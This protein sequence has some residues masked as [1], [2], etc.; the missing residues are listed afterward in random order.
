MKIKTVLPGAV[1]CLLAASCYTPRYMYSPSAQNVPVLVKK[2]DS[3]LSANYSTDL[4][5]SPFPGFSS[6]SNS[7]KNN[8]IDIQGAV[9]ITNNF[10]IQ[11][12][13]FNRRERNNGNGYN[14][15]STSISYKRNL[16]EFAV[17]YFKSMHRKDK[18]IFQVFG[19]AGKGT[20]SFTD[21]GKNRYDT[22]YTRHH[23][24]GVFKVYIQPAFIF[25]I[26][27]NF[28]LSVSTRLS[29]INFSNIKTDYTVAELEDYRLNRV[30]DG[31]HIFWEPA[32]TNTFGFNKL[33][34]IKFQYQLLASLRVS[35][36]IIDYRSFNF[37]LGML[38]DIPKIFQP[39][40]GK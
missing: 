40:P 2:G 29:I 19:G 5:G 37:S 39:G 25:R 31:S 27:E 8:G 35:N 11:A 14:V 32:F 16:T 13:Y 4:S 24:A 10:A 17:G 18:I 33:P 1:I 7:T 12:S 21:K 30:P 34:G 9:A 28:T 6:G 26:K 22:S 38:L 3:R 15:D 23:Q 36:Q 20:F